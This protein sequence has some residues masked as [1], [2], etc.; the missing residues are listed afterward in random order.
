[1]LY[2][3]RHTASATPL[4]KP[5]NVV[6]VVVDGIVRYFSDGPAKSATTV[7]GER[8]AIENG[9]TSV[10]PPRDEIDIA[11]KPSY[12]AGLSASVD[13]RLANES[14]S[15]DLIDHGAVAELA[16]WSPEV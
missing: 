15:H 12:R 13:L 7:S 5:C 3:I 6:T 9:L 16:I 14:K 2:P 4:R 10:S 8:I 11:P 1:M